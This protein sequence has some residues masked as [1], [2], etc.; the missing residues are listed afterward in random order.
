MRLSNKDSFLI[1]VYKDFNYYCT[2]YYCRQRILI[3]TKE[4]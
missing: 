3:D 1:I 4:R 2:L